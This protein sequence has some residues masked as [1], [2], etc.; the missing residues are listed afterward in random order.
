[1]VGQKKL[2]IADDEPALLELVAATLRSEEYELLEAVDGPQ[3]LEMVQREHPMLALLDVGMPGMS[4]LEVCR[5]IRQSPETSDTAVVIL[6]ASNEPEHREAALAAG[7]L[8]YLTKPF[9]PL[10]LLQLVE[11]V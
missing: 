2:L 5:N 11:Q 8:A 1:M 3:A 4:G 10:Q 7:A 6:T 9:S